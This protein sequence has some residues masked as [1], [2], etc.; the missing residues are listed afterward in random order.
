[1]NSDSKK[2][3]LLS[4]HDVEIGQSIADETLVNCSVN[5]FKFSK[6]IDE[7]LGTTEYWTP[8]DG[9]RQVWVNIE[10]HQL[11]KID[12][13]NQLFGSEFTVTQS[14]LW[15]KDDVKRNQDVVKSEEKEDRSESARMFTNLIKY[16]KSLVR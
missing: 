9:P 13:V 8:T 4:C 11:D 6:S 14:W 12:T 7:S 2:E 10:V 3:P 16:N 1:M 15:S 5:D